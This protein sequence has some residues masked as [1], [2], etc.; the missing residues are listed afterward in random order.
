MVEE[1]RCADADVV[2]V[3]LGS[4]IGTSRIVVDKMR[5]QGLKVGLVK[6][7]FYRP[8]PLEYFKALSKRVKAVGVI[9]RDLSFGYEGAVAS[10]IKSALNTSGPS[11]K[12]INFIAGIAG[13]DITKEN[14]EEMYHKLFNLAQGKAEKELQFTGLRW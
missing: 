8:F 11:P 2:L 6:L 14:I 10:D 13:R 4:A 3:A 12:V 5:D 9:D 1:Y 7:R